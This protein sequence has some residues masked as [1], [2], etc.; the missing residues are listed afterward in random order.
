MS[1]IKDN[2]TI[3]PYEKIP[4]VWIL[5]GSF[6]KLG[7]IDDYTSLIW[8]R[9][10]YEVGDFELYVRVTDKNMN[11]L[12]VDLSET[13]RFIMRNDTKEVMRIEKVEISVDAEEGDFITASGRDLR[14]LLYQR[15]TMMDDLFGN[16]IESPISGDI[17]NADAVK[18]VDVIYSLVNDNVV[19]PHYSFTLPFTGLVITIPDEDRMMPL[20]ETGKK[21][22]IEGASTSSMVIDVGTNVGEKV[23]IRQPSETFCFLIIFQSPIR[24]NTGIW[25]LMGHTWKVVVMVLL[26]M[27]ILSIIMVRM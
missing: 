3:E 1:E 6:Q 15:C 22:E 14:C 2:Y 17:T 8:S 27:I 5:N 23:A 16:S 21:P 12:N 19:N 20:V 26:C 10:Y 11:L 9:R 4:D 25:K 24:L 13:A 18:I 7:L